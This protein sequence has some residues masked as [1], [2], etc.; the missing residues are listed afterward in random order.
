MIF[1]IRFSGLSS[2]NFH[3]PLL[4]LLSFT[5]LFFHITSSAQQPSAGAVSS[6]I[7]LL[8]K[9]IQIP[10]N[11]GSEREAGEFLKQQCIQRG[12]HIKQFSDSACQYNFAASIYPLELGKPNIIFL[13]HID[14]VPVD[15]DEAW[16]YPPYSGT[17][18]DNKIWGRGALDC[19]S[20]AVIQLSAIERILKS[21][22]KKV[23]P[24]NITLLCVSGE[25]TGGITGSAVV[26]EN[27]MAL[28]HPAVIIGEGGSGMENVAFL[29]PG[30]KYFGISIAEKSML[31]LKLS[32]DI[33]SH[34]HSSVPTSDY[35]N[36]RLI[37][38]LNRILKSKV[39]IQFTDEAKL[40]FRSAATH[41]KGIKGF[42]M[43]N[44]SS[45]VFR[46]TIKKYIRQNPEL[47]A[48]LCNT[49]TVSNLS[50]PVTQPNQIPQYASAV[51][52]CR[53]LPG[54]SPESMITYFNKI[55][56]DSFIKVNVINQA[57]M[58]L[59][60]QPEYFYGHLSEAL[61]QTFK[62]AAVVPMLLP[63]STDNSYFRS[64][65]YP[66]Y[67]LNPFMLSSLQIKSIHNSNE[68]IDIEDIE[69][70]INVFETFLRTVI[71]DAA[72][73]RD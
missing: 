66:A 72:K 34:G 19:K 41:V 16:T 73:K 17:I 31:W 65:G 43:K 11:P 36:K 56:N 25:E 1:L 8:S 67:G 33:R 30:K 63:A 37:E 47:E 9:Y 53:L 51:L 55:I 62:D 24:Y 22:D 52:D 39:P 60:T 12:L 28:L 32:C 13:N 58:S 29:P 57:G 59:S 61:K 49:I 68:F 10:S 7:A 6:A 20:L 44:I 15:M 45:P 54:V 71:E 21:V 4:A 5:L 2:F 27:F 35:S 70:G 26:A 64:K 23:L 14:V 40:M 48:I 42:A 18:A 50:N 38:A 3:K 46:P 69:H